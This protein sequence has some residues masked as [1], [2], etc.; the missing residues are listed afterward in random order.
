MTEPSANDVPPKLSE[1]DMAR[2]AEYLNSPSHRRERAP[3]R[4]WT[5][6]LV[7][8]VVVSVISAVSMFYAW[9]QGI[10]IL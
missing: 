2:V 4:P 10:R 8:T 3:F 7:L 1:E 9:Q 5:L 6:L